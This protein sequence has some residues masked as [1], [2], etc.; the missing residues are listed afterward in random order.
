MPPARDVFSSIILYKEEKYIWG[1][2]LV[3]QA[4]ISLGELKVSKEFFE[5][6]LLLL[7][8]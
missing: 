6:L 2:P 5:V 4:S 1:E 3:S 8:Y 7:A